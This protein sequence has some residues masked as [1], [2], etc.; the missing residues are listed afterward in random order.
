MARKRVGD[1]LLEAGVITEEQL[2]TALKEQK[3]THERLG[4]VLVKLGFLND[5][6]LSEVLAH[7]SGSNLVDLTEISISPETAK[8]LPKSF[9]L[10]N[11]VIPLSK[12]GNRIVIAMS[13]PFDVVTLDM[14]AL[15][16]GSEVKVSVA[17]E[18]EILAAV[19][20][21][22][23]DEEM[24]LEL[25]P[26]PDKDAKKEDLSEIAFRTEIKEGQDLSSISPD[27]IF[28]PLETLRIVPQEFCTSN[29]VIPLRKGDNYL[30]VGIADPSDV[31][32]LDMLKVM[33]G[34]E[35]K[36]VTFSEDDI[37]DLLAKFYHD[38]LA[39]EELVSV[40]SD[41]AA[42]E[43]VKS[44]DDENLTGGEG[45]KNMDLQQLRGKSETGPVIRLANSLIIE[46]IKMRAS[47]IH[48]EPREAATQVRC[49]VDGLLKNVTF[50]PL[51]VHGRLI[52]RIKV[53]GGMDISETRNP[54]DGRCRVRM[55]KNEYDIR[56][57]TVPTFYGEKLVMRILDQSVGAIGL[58]NLGFSLEDY[59]KVQTSITA[60]QGIILVTGPTGSG[61]SSTLFS[62]LEVLKSE[63]KNIITV[64]D[65]I[66]YDV[67]GIN[68]M[69]VNEKAG[70]TFPS[71]LRHI[72]RQDPDVIMIGEIRDEETAEIAFHAAMTGHLVLSTLH[73]NDAPTTIVRLNELGISPYLIAASLK[74]V[75]AQRLVRTICAKCREAYPAPKDVVEM[76]GLPYTE[77]LKFY[78]GKGCKTCGFTGYHGRTGIFEVLTLNDPIKDLIY[79]EASALAITEAARKHGM[80]MLMEDAIN[81]VL[82]GITTPEE[83]LR[84]ISRAEILQH[85]KLCPRCN[86][87]LKPEYTACP[88]C[89]LDLVRKKCE[90]CGREL[91]EGVEICPFCAGSQ[92]AFDLKE[93][94]APAITTAPVITCPNCNEPVEEDW[95]NCPACNFP[96]KGETEKFKRSTETKCPSC[97]RILGS[98]WLSCPYCGTTIK[99]ASGWPVA[100]PV[101]AYAHAQSFPQAY[102]TAQ[103]YQAPP[104]PQYQQILSPAYQYPYPGY[105]Q[106]G[107]FGPYQQFG[108]PYQYQYPPVQQ[109]PPGDQ[110]VC[111]SCHQPVNEQWSV[112]PYCAASLTQPASS[113]IALCNNC[114]TPV[115]PDWKVCP[116]CGLPLMSSQPSSPPTCP[117]CHIQV[118]PLWKICPTCATPLTAMAVQ[119][120]PSSELICPNCSARLNPEWAACPFCQT[121]IGTAKKEETGNK[122]P[123][124]NVKVEP[125]WN[126]CPNC[127]RRI[128][129]R[130]MDKGVPPK[131]VGHESQPEAEVVPIRQDKP[132]TGT[133]GKILIIDDDPKMLVMLK[134]VL[135]DDKY[136]VDLVSDGNDGLQK[137]T[138]FKPDL[139]IVDTEMPEID[140]FT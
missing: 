8:L 93:E 58:E 79:K 4:N 137:I 38:D 106:P 113:G 133:K 69:Q 126:F 67:S 118:S 123:F 108:S 28:I 84:V 97:G 95:I 40:V 26:S 55:G 89:G 127:H 87:R 120:Q 140:G 77:D 27:K 53:M 138:S 3:K 105:Y 46:A 62:I 19:E 129:T 2:A 81:K 94:K 71:L 103:Q 7:Q 23:F 101:T 132:A 78:K 111:P 66:E 73:T 41:S 122:C 25:V 136:E 102:S 75:I 57:S 128:D 44:G 139:V 70:L 32:T 64:E 5:E 104:L 88:Q 115:Q 36:T 125:G 49:R 39:L 37:L 9:C 29:K 130:D 33:T 47:D 131:A 31:V 65:P 82:K 92:E 54:Q 124:C 91:E 107:P 76:L 63:T 96:L 14:V 18:N 6:E 68:Q 74:S 43:V 109:P 119:S 22:C 72:L 56:I 100:E 110:K 34:M 15:F 11:K 35:I 20:K 59:E 90:K 80:K 117:V 83:V 114:W 121:P 48:I 99:Q 1:L 112:C 61:K 52:S 17:K 12:D 24:D 51:F 10:E 45:V 21:F 30:L 60:Q 134:K 42:V 135:E 85:G 116:S 50:L 16:T 13:D 98:D 86:T